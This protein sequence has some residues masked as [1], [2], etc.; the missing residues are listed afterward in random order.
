M[1]TVLGNSFSYSMKLLFLNSCLETYL[2][3]DE[4]KFAS[5]FDSRLGDT[6][7]YFMSA[8]FPIYAIIHGII[9]VH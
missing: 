9:R 8:V 2:F 5:L 7:G 4:I 6:N 3:D 1:T